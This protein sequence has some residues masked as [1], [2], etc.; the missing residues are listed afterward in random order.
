MLSAILSKAQM[1]TT[2]TELF[3]HFYKTNAK[4]DFELRHVDF[5]GN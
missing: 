2:K 4:R 1:K 5:C 3:G